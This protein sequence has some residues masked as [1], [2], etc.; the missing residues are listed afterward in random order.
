M[1]PESDAPITPLE[2]SKVSTPHT[3][4]EEENPFP[5]EAFPYTGGILAS[6]PP[7]YVPL[8][9]LVLGT[10]S[11]SSLYHNPVW[12]SGTMPTLG[13]FDAKT[14]SQQVVISAGA[15]HH[16]EYP[17]IVNPNYPLGT[18]DS[19]EECLCQFFHPSI[20]CPSCAATWGGT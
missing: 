20:Q 8:A 5:L 12:A 6:L 13:P 2:D 11:A 7:N 15:T 19:F 1:E 4:E 16:S 10:P 18:T 9:Q 17:C 3:V 14:T